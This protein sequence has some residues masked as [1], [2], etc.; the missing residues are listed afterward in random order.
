MRKPLA[1]R[2]PD[3]PEPAP[4]SSLADHF[5]SKVFGL[6]YETPFL[7]LDLHTVSEAYERLRLA[8]PSGTEI[9]FAMKCNADDRL[10]RTVRDLG[11]GFVVASYGELAVLRDLGIAASAADAGEVLFSNPVKRPGDVARA[12]AAGVDRF[13]FDSEREAEKLAEL[14]PGSRVYVRLKTRAA[15]SA[16]PSEG[17]FGVPAG[18]ATRLMLYAVSLGLVPYGITFHVGSQ[19]TDTTAW[20]MAIA[21]AAAVMR[22]LADDGVRIQMLDMGGGFPVQYEGAAVP[23]ISA[24]GKS[25]GHALDQLPYPVRTVVEPGRFLAAPA[26]V[27]VASV[28]GVAERDGARWV[29]LDA[30]AFNGFMES[31]ETSNA[32]RY[33]VTDS[34]GQ[35]S[36]RTTHLT[37]PSCDSQDT[38]MFGVELS[39]DLDV[40]D[41]VAIW[42]TGAYTLVYA[43]EAFNGIGAPSAY[44]IDRAM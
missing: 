40:G 29:H 13:A 43:T 17:K 41:A 32:L 11:G 35:A 1:A 18:H 6:S 33:P 12:F 20:E 4:C 34:R 44:L 31:L 3:G 37:G 5:G 25:I 30:G 28:I 7:G 39:R 2:T 21:E 27:M 42:Q 36:T 8:L 22:A 26:G 24:I 9:K 14:A 38:I 16:V 23:S 15:Q 10:L 19:M